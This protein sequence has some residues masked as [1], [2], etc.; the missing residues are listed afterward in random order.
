M[1]TTG[2]YLLVDEPDTGLHWTALDGMWR[3][4]LATARRLDV[5]IFATTHSYDCI[6]GLASA[7]KAEP[8][9]RDDVSTSSTRSSTSRSV[10]R[11][12]T[13]I[14]MAQDEVR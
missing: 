13:Q 1:T 3:L 5:Q 10:F 14:A 7:I 4:L 9:L 12:T 8:D 11:P 2:G 6:H